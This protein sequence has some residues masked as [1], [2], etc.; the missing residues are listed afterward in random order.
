MSVRDSDIAVRIDGYPYAAQ[1]FAALRAHATQIPA[2]EFFFKL[3][4]APPGPMW[5]ECF[6]LAGGLPFDGPADDVF[7]GFGV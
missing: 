6:R 1:R 4:D 5:E 3:Q 7:A 2:G